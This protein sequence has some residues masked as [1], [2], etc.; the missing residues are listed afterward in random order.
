MKANTLNIL[1]ISILLPLLWGSIG[2]NERTLDISENN[3][4]NSSNNQNTNKNSND[5]CGENTNSAADC[6]IITLCEAVARCDN[7]LNYDDCIAAMETE[8]GQQIWDDFGLAESENMLTT[9]HVRFNISNGTIDINEPALS[10]CTNELM[11]TCD[12]DGEAVSIETY[13]NVENLISEEGDCP[14]VL[15]STE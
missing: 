15:S 2:C 13:D 6:L 4:S 9:D 5:P 12:K 10:N 14:L 3:E 1:T 8:P 7:S 11:A